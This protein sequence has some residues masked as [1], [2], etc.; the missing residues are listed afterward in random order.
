MTQD[1]AKAIVLRLFR[2]WVSDNGKRLPHEAPEGGL[3]FYGWLGKEHPEALN[4]RATGDK[5]Q[6]VH[7]WLLNA[8]MVSH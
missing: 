8:R 4:F 6:V 2:Q 5:W 3:L 1:Q 7:G